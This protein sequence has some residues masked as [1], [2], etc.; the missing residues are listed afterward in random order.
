MP[1]WTIENLIEGSNG[2][3][4][5]EGHLDIT[6]FSI[7]SRTLQPG[8]VFFP[9]K[10]ENFDGHNFINSAIEQKAAAIILSDLPEHI[11]PEKTTII[12]VKDTVVALQ[13]LARFHRQRHPAKFIGVTG[14]NG[15]TTTKEML[16]FLFSEFG[17]TQAT[18][19]NL[20]NHLGLPLT[21][22]RLPL[23]VKTAI[24]EMGMNHEGE[25]RFLA[26]IAKPDI[27]IITNIGPAHIGILGSLKNIAKAK[28]EILENLSPNSY[29]IIPGD[30]EFTDFLK[31]TTKGK[32][33]SI[34]K[35]NHNDF[36]LTNY[37]MHSAKLN[38]NFCFASNNYEA[39]IPL[40]GRHNALNALTA[41]AA[42]KTIGHPITQGLKRLEKMPS[43]NARMELHQQQGKQI[44]LDC[45]NANP[46]SMEEALNFLKSTN[47]PTIAVLGDMKE[48]GEK[49]QELHFNLGAQA[50][51]ANLEQLICVGK[52]AR[53]IGNGAIK[54]GMSK[55]SVSI[56]N[57][58]EDAAEL[59]RER[60]KKGDTVLFKASRGMHFE[61]IVKALWPNLG[62]DLH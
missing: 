16:S 21:M 12:Q 53:H 14:S 19:G 41:L 38:F 45:Y 20:N 10:G 61:E 25:I 47:S 52:D 58:N 13:S 43:I 40:I 4:I 26:E 33:L 7:D 9:I 39:T 62:K 54:N 15:K 17:K 44:I 42:Y 29:A 34:G 8:D 51:E 37:T 31:E 23:D 6:G 1:N 55:D 30:S 5:S 35:A 27:A 57:S 50:A 2:K 49:S 56:L 18:E 36:Q 48:L 22:L 11:A 24:L 60:L 46:S 32:I 3:L 59:L 28:S